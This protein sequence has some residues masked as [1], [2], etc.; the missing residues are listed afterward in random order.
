[1]NDEWLA[2]VCSA[3]YQGAPLIHG[4]EGD[5]E[6]GI[7]SLV[8]ML[9]EK[10]T[11]LVESGTAWM[12]FP[13]VRALAMNLHPIIVHFPIAFLSGYFLLDVIGVAMRRPS[14]R[15]AA[16]WMLYLGALGAVVAAAAG[17]IAASNVPHGDM[18]HEV[19]EWHERMM[20]TV[21]GL[22][23]VLAIWRA[24]AAGHVSS[25]M[26]QGLH[27]FLSTLMM[28]LLVLGSD[29][30]GLMVYQHGVGV[31]HL[32]QPEEASRHTH[33]EPSIQSRQ[34]SAEQP[35]IHDKPGHSH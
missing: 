18:V 13:G 14:L 26:A 4:E 29:L 10:I 28:T 32:Q 33:A 3:L 11:S 25:T 17:L 9:L 5:G 19:M 21:A 34:E 16:S 15:H 31:A 23:L 24:A 30:G 20:L 35:P 6:G 2:A 27:L 12:L 7:V 8:Q 22:A 1:M